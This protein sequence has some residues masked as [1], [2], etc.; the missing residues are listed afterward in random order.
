LEFTE[1]LNPLESVTSVWEKKC[2]FNVQ[3]FLGPQNF[4]VVRKFHSGFAIRIACGPY[5]G[6]TRQADQAALIRNP[7][8]IG[9]AICYRTLQNYTYCPSET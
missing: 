4:G 6:I 2:G 1:F 8:Y 7:S 3:V 9:I 5:R